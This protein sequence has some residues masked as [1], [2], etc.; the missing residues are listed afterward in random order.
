VVSAGVT[1][2]T[3]M[4]SSGV[5]VNSDNVVVI[6]NAIIPPLTSLFSAI[7]TI[8]VTTKT[9]N[10]TPFDSTLLVTTGGTDTLINLGYGALAQ[11]LAYSVSTFEIGGVSYSV[12]FSKIINIKKVDSGIGKV[13]VDG[14][15]STTIDGLLTRTLDAQY[16]NLTLQYDGVNWHI[17]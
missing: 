4:N 11:Q 8:P 14:R 2:A 12:P 6:N 7:T 17:L 1:G 16:D 9:Y 3:I 13:V 15:L 10:M 5:T